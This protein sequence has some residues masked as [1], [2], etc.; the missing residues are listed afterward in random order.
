MRWVALAIVAVVGAWFWLVFQK[1]KAISN[2]EDLCFTHAYNV[3]S[4]DAQAATTA[5]NTELPSSVSNWDAFKEALDA[6]SQRY[7]DRVNAR[8]DEE[9]IKCMKQIE[10]T[11]HRCSPLPTYP[12]DPKLCSR[13]VAQL[14]YDAPF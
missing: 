11:W 9:T 13:G 6:R 1:D 3:A 14:I 12:G 8:Y 5:E 2:F 4:R 10:S 7:T